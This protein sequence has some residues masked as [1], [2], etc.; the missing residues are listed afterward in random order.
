MLVGLVVLA[1]C[2][3]GDG[4]PTTPPTS[5]PISGLPATVV[6]MTTVPVVTTVPAAATTEP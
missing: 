1:A 5:V 3:G 2:G 6:I 4:S